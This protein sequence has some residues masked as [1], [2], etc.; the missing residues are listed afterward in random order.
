[1]TAGE[2]TGAAGEG[3]TVGSRTGETFSALSVLE[4]VGHEKVPMV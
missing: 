2:T 3:R 1:M 4:D